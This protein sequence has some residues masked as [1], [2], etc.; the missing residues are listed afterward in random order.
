MELVFEKFE[1]FL[2]V[3]QSITSNK[4]AKAEKLLKNMGK[5]IDNIDD[6]FISDSSEFFDI[7]PDG[8]LVKVN[9]YISRK[10]IRRSQLNNIDIKSLNKYH[11]YKCGALKEMFQLGRKEDYKINT[12]DTGLFHYT[13]YDYGHLLKT[14][15]NQKLNICKW[16]LSMFLNNSYAS[17]NDVENFNLKRF[18]EKNES[19]FDF[20][21]SKLE[22]GEEAKINVYSQ[23]WREI[24][25]Q[26]KT[27]KDYT[28]EE[29]GWKPNDSYEKRFVHTHHQNR[30]KTN[31]T[32]ENL[33]V[34]CIECHSNVDGYHTQIKSSENYKEF[35]EI[36]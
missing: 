33:K 35:I 9:L 24:S 34:L 2:N 29:C 10:N 28:C 31:N 5:D 22:K 3:I 11:I 8:T 7:L 21:T 13:F 6:I 15:E 1:S 27:R 17:D 36:K 23:R 30:D 19:F 14:E 20:D 18:Y 26:F 4:L 25:T 12:R 16:C 32:K